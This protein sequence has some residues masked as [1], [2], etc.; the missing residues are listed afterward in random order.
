MER[1]VAPTK[2]IAPVSLFTL[3]VKVGDTVS[4]IGRGDTGNG[5]TGITA[6][7]LSLRVGENQLDKVKGQWLRFTFDAPGA[8]ALPLEAISGGG[9]SGSPAYVVSNGV[10]HIVGLSA[11]QDT[12]ATNWQQGLYGV[13]DYY[14]NLSFYR[15]WVNQQLKKGDYRPLSDNKK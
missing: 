2:A 12:Q 9:D 11:W 15:S 8:G 6:S 1:V 4:I 13:Q 3:P 7:D 10:T 5:L 14:S